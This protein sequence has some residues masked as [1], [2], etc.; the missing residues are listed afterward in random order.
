MVSIMQSKYYSAEDA[1]YAEC[2][3]KAR[4]LLEVLEAFRG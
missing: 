2:A 4:A 1:E 3:D